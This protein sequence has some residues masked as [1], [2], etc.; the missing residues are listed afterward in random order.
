MAIETHKRTEQEPT[1][2]ELLEFAL[3]ADERT[4]ALAPSLHA[5]LVEAIPECERQLAKLPAGS[6]EAARVK[7]DLAEMRLAQEDIKQFISS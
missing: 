7:N 1:D 3:K 4:A 6:L 5:F 2:E